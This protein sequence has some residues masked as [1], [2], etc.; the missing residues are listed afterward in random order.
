MSCFNCGQLEHF[1][2]YCSNVEFKGTHEPNTGSSGVRGPRR[3]KSQGKICAM[4]QSK[5][6]DNHHVITS[7][8]M[9]FNSPTDLLFDS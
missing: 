6:R 8:L 3:P 5:A 9:I 4:T 2:K 7:S 1:A